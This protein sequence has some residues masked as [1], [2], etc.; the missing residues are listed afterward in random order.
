MQR[1]TGKL[2]SIFIDVILTSSH[3]TSPNHTTHSNNVNTLL[4]LAVAEKQL[5]LRILQKTNGPVPR[6]YLPTLMILDI[7]EKSATDSVA[8][9]AL[10]EEGIKWYLDCGGRASR[11]EM[12]VPPTLIDVIESMGFSRSSPSQPEALQ[13]REMVT[14]PTDYVVMTCD[15]PRLRTHCEERGAGNKGIGNPHVIYDI[16]GRL[17]HDMGDPKAS[18][19]PY[20]SS[21]QAQPQS[22][23]VFRNMG[24]AYHAA[25]DMQLAFAS[26]QQAVQLDETDAL[27]YLKLAFFYEDFASKDWIDAAEHSQKCYE[28]YL[29]KVDPGDTAVLTRLGNLLVRE[30]KPDQAV[31][32]FTRALDLDPGLENV[33]F[34]QAH[35]QMT[36]GDFAGAS[37]SLR[38]TLEIDPT[39]IA[40]RH[41][42]KALSEEEATSANASEEDYV[43]DLFDTYAKV[44]DTHV[45]KLLYS[46]TRVIRQELA[47]IYRSKHG[48]YDTQQAPA[49]SFTPIERAEMM[50]KELEAEQ[51]RKD[52]E[53]IEFTRTTE[54]DDAT[55]DFSTKYGPQNDTRE[56]LGYKAMGA[57][58]DFKEAL[59]PVGSSCSSYSSFMNSSLDILDIGCGTGLAGNGFL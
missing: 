26:Y 36:I 39:I 10:I 17:A 15:A 42:L 29:D 59:A 24:S 3:L 51:R 33:W 38:K 20:T 5:T 41:M 25:G 19:K 47:T 52:I 31:R 32:V 12:S 27:V 13:L 40:A 50:K 1:N 46:A 58:D 54:K 34:N 9:F 6:S 43:K 14:Y 18:I 56:S 55:P 2:P 22:A 37:H 21:L 49:F 7:L 57:V 28:Y 35:A 8:I 11:L 30:H 4:T 48:L 23:A 53:M 44:Y 45:K 16:V